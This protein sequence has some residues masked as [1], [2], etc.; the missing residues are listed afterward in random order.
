MDEFFA[1]CCEDED[2]L[3]QEEVPTKAIAISRAENEWCGRCMGSLRPYRFES[4]ARPNKE[5]KE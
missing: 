3:W 1:I 4:M 2:C 5:A